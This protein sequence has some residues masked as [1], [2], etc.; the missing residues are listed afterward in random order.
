MDGGPGHVHPNREGE[1]NQSGAVAGSGSQRDQAVLDAAMQKWLCQGAAGVPWRLDEVGASAATI[2]A[3]SAP[4]G[5]AGDQRADGD[6][7]VRLDSRPSPMVPV[8]R[9]S[10][11]S[12]RLVMASLSPAA[13]GL[14]ACLRALDQAL[15]FSL[16]CV[17]GARCSATT[18]ARLSRMQPAIMLKEP[19]V[20]HLADQR[21][22]GPAPGRAGPAARPRRLP[23]RP[24]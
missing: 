4:T 17:C 24:S 15:R 18:S 3:A 12:E 10:A 8:R 21:R 23:R 13:V 7:Q 22:L 2:Q 9:R 1:E 20:G 6:D 5:R 14:L 19:E 16:R 11:W